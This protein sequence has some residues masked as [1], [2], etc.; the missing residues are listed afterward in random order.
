MAYI[1][2]QDIIDRLTTETAARLTTESGSTPSTT[3]LD[4][5]RLSAEGEV[6]SYLSKRYKVPV[7]LTA[8]ADLAATLKGYTLD[9][10][11]YR[12]F[13]RRPPVPESAAETYKSAK[14]WLAKVSEGKLPLPASVTPA[15]TTSDD[16]PA[17]YGGSP[18]IVSREN[19]GVG[20][21]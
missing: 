16:P 1:V 10:A 6:N 17:G 8:H 18:S 9:V 21:E 12:A 19:W 4:E 11:V 13:V 2:N 3:V 14:E 20:G 7:D 15:S 5:I